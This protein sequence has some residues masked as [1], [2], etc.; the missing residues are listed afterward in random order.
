MPARTKTVPAGGTATFPVTVPMPRAAGDT[1]FSLQF[2][3]DAGTH[4]SLPV[5]RRT[6]VPLDPARG[7]STTFTARIKG[8][9]GRGLGQL[10]GYYL[11]V[12]AGRRN[13]T[14]DLT[15]QDAGTE[16]DYYLVSP[17]QQVLARDANRTVGKKSTPTKYAS[18]T[19]DRPAA[20]R[21]TL[22]VAVPDAVSG[23]EFSQQVTGRVRLDAA[24]AVTAPGLP[25]SASTVVKQGSKLKV[26]V[27]VAN[28]GPA[29]RSY[30]L[31]PRLAGSA[32]VVLPSI[33]G[34]T[35]FP[36]NGPDAESSWV[37]THTT[38]VHAT[39]TAD[40]PVEASLGS[41][42]HWAEVLGTPGPD[43]SVTVTETA[44]QLSAGGWWVS[45]SSPGPFTD[46]PAPKGTAKVTVTA[47]TQPV[48]PAAQA[49]TGAFWDHGG[50]HEPVAV[51]AGRTGT[52]TLTLA[53][54]AAV[55]TVVHGILYV[56]TESAETSANGYGSEIIGIPYTYTVG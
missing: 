32:D 47:T 30:F 19:V 13:L 16:L 5:A 3:S 34:K 18:L 23:K 45:V 2:T 39:V 41:P 42:L 35:T 1:P 21:W 29:N 24:T 36:V 38:A 40:T 44:D 27:R 6:L 55:G 9:V 7:H 54:T 50:K 22:I 26:T 12:P 28:P 31:D 4:L 43:G 17:Q 52:M 14:V 11:D 53:P 20:G 8:G 56:D 33:D 48:D 37:P 25:D 49:S 46:S 51:A 10:G 15:A